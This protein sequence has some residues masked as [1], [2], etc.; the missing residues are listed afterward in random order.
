MENNFLTV[1][2]RATKNIPVNMVSTICLID[3][4]SMLDKLAKDGISFGLT[5]QWRAQQPAQVLCLYKFVV[6]RIFIQCE[7]ITARTFFI[8]STILTLKELEKL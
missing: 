6:I 2:S 5:L 1:Q 3:V 8:K 7:P 4:D